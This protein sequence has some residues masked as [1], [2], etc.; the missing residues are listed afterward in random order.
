MVFR[1]QC[2]CKITPAEENKR[3]KKHHYAFRHILD[4]VVN[5]CSILFTFFPTSSDCTSFGWYFWP[6]SY[7]IASPRCIIYASK[8]TDSQFPASQRCHKRV[9]EMRSAC[10][11][12]FPANFPNLN[13][14]YVRTMLF[15]TTRLQHTR[16]D[17][18]YHQTTK[19]KL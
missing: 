9:A 10:F 11:C 12:H 7:R 15:P 4:S 3:A 18:H 5:L 16:H 14:N 2:K 13:V 17:E 1:S 19:N 6:L 8:S